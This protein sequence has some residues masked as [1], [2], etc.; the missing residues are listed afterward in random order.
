[1]ASLNRSDCCFKPGASPGTDILNEATLAVLR[2]SIGDENIANLL[3][4]FVV[5]AQQRFLSEPVAREE[6]PHVDVIGRWC[7]DRPCW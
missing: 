5:E 7:S 1:M 6:V 4:L 2:T 3:K